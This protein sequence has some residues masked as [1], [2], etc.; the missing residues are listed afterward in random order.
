MRSNPG[1]GDDRTRLDL[2]GFAQEFLRR[3]PRYRSDYRKVAPVPPDRDPAM[4]QEVMA[5]H[6]GL[7]FPVLTR[8]ICGGYTGV[9]ASVALADHRHHR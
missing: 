4:A 1:I 7:A 2:A 3:N 5:R 6:W 8:C 9:V